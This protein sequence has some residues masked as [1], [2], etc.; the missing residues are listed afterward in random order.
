[1]RLIGLVVVLTLG[2]FTPLVGQAQQQPPVRLR[3]DR[4]V[5]QHIVSA[6]AM[7]GDAQ[8]AHAGIVGHDSG[9]RTRRG[10]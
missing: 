6:E 3:I 4:R 5:E 9:Q 1:M 10:H 7:R 2:L 8:V